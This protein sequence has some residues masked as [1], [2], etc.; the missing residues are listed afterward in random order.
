MTWQCADC[1]ARD[2]TVK[3]YVLFSVHTGRE[4]DR[5]VRLCDNCRDDLAAS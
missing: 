5:R 3:E 2:S 4:D 1:D